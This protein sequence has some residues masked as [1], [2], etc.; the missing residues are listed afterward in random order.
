MMLFKNNSLAVI[1]HA[2]KTKIDAI[3][4]RLSNLSCG[5]FLLCFI[6]RKTMQQMPTHILHLQDQTYKLMLQLTKELN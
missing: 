1:L 3:L 2:A 6:L 4:L 5:Y